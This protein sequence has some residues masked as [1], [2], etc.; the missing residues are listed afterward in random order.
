LEKSQTKY[1]ARHGLHRVDHQF[2]VG[3]QVWLYIGKERMKGEGKKIKPIHYGPFKILDKIVTNAFW[4]ELPPYMKIYSVVNVEN[5]RLYEPSMIED[6]GENVHIP[7]IEYFSPE[8]MNELQED[9]ILDK[10]V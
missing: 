7:T 1:K 3:D 10:R 8:Y 2:K 9:T 6:Q 5:L 4:L